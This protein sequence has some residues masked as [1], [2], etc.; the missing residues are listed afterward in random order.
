MTLALA[1]A[2]AG[3]LGLLIVLLLIAGTYFLLRSLN[4]QLHKVPR[5]FDDVPP[6][7]RGAAARTPAT[8]TSPVD[9]PPDVVR[10]R[11]VGDPP[12]QTAATTSPA[13]TP[14]AAPTPSG[15]TSIPPRHAPSCLLDV[16]RSRDGDDREGAA[17]GRVTPRCTGA[18]A[19]DSRGTDD[20]Q[21]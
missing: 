5:S 12:Q 9:E 16:A 13:P 2:Q 15:S 21:D 8:P 1:G 10:P 6:G 18:A 7:R 17:S 14:I 3:T 4:T 11:D 19:D 20:D